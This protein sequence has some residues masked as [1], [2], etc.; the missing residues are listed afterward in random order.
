MCREEEEVEEEEED[1]PVCCLVRRGSV[2]A[3][4]CL[5]PRED[6]ERDFWWEE[7]W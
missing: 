1:A 7:D 6:N 5:D 2:A 4:T 3:W